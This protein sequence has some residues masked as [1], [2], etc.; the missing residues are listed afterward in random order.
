MIGKWHI[1][2]EAGWGTAWDYQKIWNR[3]KYPENAHAYYEAQ[4]IET[5]GGEAKMV[6]GYPTDFYT[7]WGVDFINGKG[8]DPDKPWFLWLCYPTAHGPFTPPDRNL[9]LFPDVSVPA[10]KD[11]YPPR[12]GK[13]SYMQKIAKW[14]QG[15]D[16]RPKMEA[17]RTPKGSTVCLYGS[18]IS[19]W[20]RQYQQVISGLDQNMARLMEALDSSGQRKETLVV[21]TADQ[22]FAFGQHGFATKMAPYDA[23][24]RPPMIFSHPG[25]IP[26]NTVCSHSISGPDLVSTILAQSGIP[27]PWPM[28]GH[29]FSPL[30]RSPDREDWDHGAL[31]ALT[32]ILWG[33]RTAHIPVLLDHIQGVPWWVSYSK[34]RYKYIRTLEFN[35]IEELYDLEQDPEELNNLALNPEYHD[36][37]E[38]FRLKTVAELKRTQ[39]PF[40]RRLPSVFK[41]DKAITSRVSQAGPDHRKEDA[42]GRPFSLR[43]MGKYGVIRQKPPSVVD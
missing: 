16:G 41:L 7:D 27:E 10:P 1:G 40:V 24:I 31:L 19:D 5:N 25:S 2:V 30:L 34:G 4:L 37:V 43:R 42:K 21:L 28:H 18:D 3:C 36:Q 29:D 39:A 32:G 35:E 23:N 9:D 6:D 8:R 38:Q 26:E 33:D 22:G 17:F 11:V 14:T 15:S 20:N 13:P 12:P